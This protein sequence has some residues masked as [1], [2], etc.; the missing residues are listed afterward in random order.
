MEEE[1]K[2]EDGLPEIVEPKKN[3]PVEK[4][5]TIKVDKNVK[6]KKK[7]KDNKI[8][9]PKDTDSL[10]DLL[11][12][13]IKLSESI[14]EQ[15]KKIKH[16]LNMMVLGGYLKIFFIVAP[17]IF[18]YIYLA[19]MLSQVF[20]QYSSLLGGMGGGVTPN[21]GNIFSSGGSLDLNSILSNISAQDAAK[22]QEMLKNIPK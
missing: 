16:R 11:L 19:P 17:L 13:N 5:E 8:L 10:Q 15:N 2:I 1:N 22:L 18:A 14:F 7:E 20:S 4:K 9:P 21:L 6:D 3:Q 12:R